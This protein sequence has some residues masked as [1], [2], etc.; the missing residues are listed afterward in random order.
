[1]FGVFLHLCSLRTLIF[2]FTTVS[3]AVARLP[4][5]CNCVCSLEC[6]LTVCVNKTD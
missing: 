3:S 1:M 4:T 5:V 2:E 6:S